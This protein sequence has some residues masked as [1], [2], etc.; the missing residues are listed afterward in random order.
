MASVHDTEKLDERQLLATLLAV[1]Q[2]DFSVR[3]PFE[4]TGL[5]GKICD[6]LNE[7]IEL[8]QR[9]HRE[10]ERINVAVGKEGKITQRGRRRSIR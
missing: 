2:A 3:M 6:T 8:D 7:V 1:K 4:Q 10:L 9:L 5:A